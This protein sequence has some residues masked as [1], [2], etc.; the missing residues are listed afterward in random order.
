MKLFCLQLVC[1]GAS[2][3]TWRRRTVSSPAWTHLFP[4]LL[5]Q[6]QVVGGV[7][8]SVHALLVPGDSALH[9][10]S[11]GR[12]PQRKL[13]KVVHIHGRLVDRGSGRWRHL[14]RSGT[15]GGGKNRGREP[16]WDVRHVAETQCCPSL[17]RRDE[18]DNHVAHRESEWA[19]CV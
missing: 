13:L 6:V 11:L 4:I 10:D 17:G 18:C 3:H 7:H 5:L 9:S 8:A 12:G 14:L 19:H 16:S 1:K 2:G 15:G